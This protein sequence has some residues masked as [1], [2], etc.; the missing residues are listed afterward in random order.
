MTREEILALRPGPEMNHLV[1]LHVMGHDWTKRAVLFGPQEPVERRDGMTWQEAKEYLRQSR[2]DNIW[3]RDYDD[4]LHNERSW[5][6]YL[7]PYQ[8]DD[9]WQERWQGPDRSGDM[10][11]A[12]E[13]AEKLKLRG[14]VVNWLE[15][16]PLLREVGWHCYIPCGHAEHAHRFPRLRTFRS[17]TCPICGRTVT[18]NEKR[19][20][21]YTKYCSSQCAAVARSA[22]SRLSLEIGGGQV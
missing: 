16:A 13:V 1:D 20:R 14:I 6:E 12:W 7:Y 4:E 10:S 19:I 3:I 9:Y 17:I 21:D 22:P 8:S 2:Y 5:D 18:S 15:I 11:A